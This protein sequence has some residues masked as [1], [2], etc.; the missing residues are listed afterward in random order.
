M[1]DLS[2]RQTFSDDTTTGER[3]QLRGTNRVTVVARAEDSDNFEWLAGLAHDFLPEGAEPKSKNLLPLVAPNDAA[4]RLLH[5]R[6]QGYAIIIV[7]LQA[8]RRQ[9][10][11]G[12]LD[13]L[14]HL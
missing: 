12:L 2:R 6:I 8:H 11:K 13:R 1:T 3:S 7:D 4:W 9:I 10:A 14:S 5:R